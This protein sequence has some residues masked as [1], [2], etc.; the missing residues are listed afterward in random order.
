[1]GEAGEEYCCRWLKV[2]WEVLQ[3]FTGEGGVESTFSKVKFKESVWMKVRGGRGRS[4]VHLLCVYTQTPLIWA[5]WD[6]ALSVTQR[7]CKLALAYRSCNP[8]MEA[9]EVIT[10]GRHQV[11]Q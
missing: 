6:R 2:V 1:M 11:M 3:R 10:E 5:A 9:S 8:L 4:I 7:I